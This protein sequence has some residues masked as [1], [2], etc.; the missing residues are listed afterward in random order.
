MIHYVA[1]LRA[2][3]VG[4][5]VVKMDA[6]RRLFEHAGLSDVE[7]FIASGN[8]VFSSAARKTGELELKI[9][10]QLYAALGYEVITFLRTVPEVAAVAQYQPFPEAEFA[11]GAELYVCFLRESP[12]AETERKMLVLNNKIDEFHFHQRELFW[13]RRRQLGDP[14]YSGAFVE[15]T[16]KAAAT[17]RNATTVR[18]IAARFQAVKH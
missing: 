14:A 15:R 10:A 12:N 13:L 6:L 3:N 1:F 17:A 11:A 8:V 2:I 16:L 4:G 18:K 7:T 5:H 9:E